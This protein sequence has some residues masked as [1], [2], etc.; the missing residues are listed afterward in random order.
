MIEFL[1]NNRDTDVRTE[2]QEGNTALDLAYKKYNRKAV[3]LL[4]DK[5]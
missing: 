1:I 4:E 2:D 5:M 3:K